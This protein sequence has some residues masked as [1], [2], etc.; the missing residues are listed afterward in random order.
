[1]EKLR[2]YID[3][4]LSLEIAN[5]YYNRETPDK[6]DFPLC[7]FQLEAI[8]ETDIHRQNISLIID[9]WAN[10]GGNDVIALEQLADSV[11]KRFRRLK[12]IDGEIQVSIYRDSNYRQILNDPD[13]TISRR[14][15]RYVIQYY[16]IGV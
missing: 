16:E 6:S 14:R 1:M 10:S 2:T 12:H 9:L 7:S 8:N 15:L 13:K 3:S 11:D 5:T 4:Q